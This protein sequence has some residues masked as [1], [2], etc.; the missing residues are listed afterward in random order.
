MH[1]HDPTRACMPA[2]KHTSKRT[3]TQSFTHTH[4][5]KHTHHL[6]VCIQLYDVSPLRNQIFKSSLHKYSAFGNY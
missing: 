4:C 2:R 1:I 6:R 3:H 5:V